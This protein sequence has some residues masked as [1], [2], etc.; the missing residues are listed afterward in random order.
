[1]Q[2]PQNKKK[3]SK[4]EISSSFN[5][6]K[7]KISEVISSGNQYNT[8]R[9]EKGSDFDSEYVQWSAWPDR[10]PAAAPVTSTPPIQ[11]RAPHSRAH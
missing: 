1:M 3:I 5:N 2:T 4:T 10:E 9:T 7:T 8:Q 6:E 11:R